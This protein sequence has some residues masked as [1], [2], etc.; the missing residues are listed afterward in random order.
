MDSFS[1]DVLKRE[2]KE[3]ETL[4]LLNPVGRERRGERGN[5]IRNLP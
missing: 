5:K 4:F 1:E 2:R 3:I